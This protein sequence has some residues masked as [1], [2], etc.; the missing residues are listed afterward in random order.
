M[1]CFKFF[2]LLYFFSTNFLYLGGDVT[3]LQFSEMYLGGKIKKIRLLSLK[4]VVSF[5]FYKISNPI[6]FNDS[7]SVLEK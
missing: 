5:L 2:A 6:N 1:R 4:N 3:C 7:H